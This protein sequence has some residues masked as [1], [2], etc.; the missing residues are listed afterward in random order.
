LN[1]HKEEKKKD[2][3]SQKKEEPVC[4]HEVLPP[5][6]LQDIPGK[7]KSPLLNPPAMT[8]TVPSS[9]GILKEHLLSH[10]QGTVY[11]SSSQKVNPY[12]PMGKDI[13]S[14]KNDSSL[15]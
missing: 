1:T 6:S 10:F 3:N 15:L 4:S 11:H 2:G 7:E 9:L 5:L 8:G 12:C 13:Y 14:D